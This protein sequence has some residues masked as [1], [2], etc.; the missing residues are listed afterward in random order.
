VLTSRL[1]VEYPLAARQ[2]RVTGRVVIFALVDENGR[3]Q[4][5]RIQSGV[6]SKTG[7]NEAIL[8]A[9]KKAKFRP[10]TKEGIPVKMYKIIPVDV[11][12]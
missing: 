6:P 11:N 9:V 8:N 5:A 4:S 3:V 12:P 2:E 10:A 7:V 1:S